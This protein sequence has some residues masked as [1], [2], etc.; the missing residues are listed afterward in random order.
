VRQIGHQNDVISSLEDNVGTDM[1]R[2]FVYGIKIA[3]GMPTS[4]RTQKVTLKSVVKG[5][6]S[7]KEFPTEVY[8]SGYVFGRVFRKVQE[9]II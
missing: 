6:T 8:Q 1:S 3:W 4:K 9:T 7:L 5:T 2:G